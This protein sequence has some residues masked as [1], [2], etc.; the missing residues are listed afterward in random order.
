MISPTI[1]DFLCSKGRVGSVNLG[2]EDVECVDGPCVDQPWFLLNDLPAP[3]MPTCIHYW[4]GIHEMTVTMMLMTMISKRTRLMTM[5]TMMTRR[6]GKLHW[7]QS[8]ITCYETETNNFDRLALSGVRNIHHH[9]LPHHHCHRDRDSLG[10]NYNWHRI[11]VWNHGE[12]C[13][14][15]KEKWRRWHCMRRISWWNLR[16]T[17][18]G[19]IW[20][21]IYWPP[22][23]KSP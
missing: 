1:A 17:A 14:K 3:K 7:R 19:V 10:D 2:G 6:G 22:P 21:P 9:L 11:H 16:Q 13:S 8:C 4:S 5:R 12:I 18:G 20:L 23:P 15:I